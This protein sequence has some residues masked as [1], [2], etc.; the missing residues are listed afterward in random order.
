MKKVLSLILGA[1]LL[2]NSLSAYAAETIKNAEGKQ[3]VSE[4]YAVDL[5]EL[6]EDEKNQEGSVT[7][8]EALRLAMADN[9]TIA[10]A[11]KTAQIYDQEVRQYWSYVYPQLSVSGSYTRALKAQEAITSMGKFRFS[12]DNATSG[13]AEATYLLWS[14]GAVSAGVRLG[15]LHSRSGYLQ[16]QG[17]Q[18]LIKDT[19]NS[20]CFGIILSH[21]LIQVQ[22]ESLNI[23]KDHLKEIQIKYK[24]GLASDLDILNQQVKVSNSEPPLIQA[25][26]S[27]DLG[28]LT[29]RR[30][31]NKDPQEPMSLSWQLE[32]ILKVNTP[33][34]EDLYK[35]AAQNR[36]E[37]VT[38]QLSVEMADEQVKIAKAEHFGQLSA[39]ANAAYSGSS[40]SVLIPVSSYNSSYGVSAGLQFSLPLFSGFKIDSQVKQKELTKDQAVLTLN[41][42]ERNVRIEVKKAWLNLNEAKKR[43]L[44]TKDTIS[45]ARKNLQRTNVRYRNGLASRLDLDDSSLLLYDAELQFVQAVHDA[46]TAL[47]NLSYAVGTEI[48]TY[49]NK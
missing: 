43:I 30:V 17:T 38:A 40:D 35:L 8:A 12:L 10:I 2:A 28:L 29:L 34:L 15:E 1:G 3:T 19:V 24:Q 7:I 39:F 21:A 41:E 16:L 18:N 9:T 6:K 32:D 20:L 33:E 49:E 26:N 27:Y 13:T 11:R 22:E 36:P 31:L 44:A 5:F 46:F 45:Q 37:L 48:G 4:A 25:Q 42:T 47:S 14:G 23:A